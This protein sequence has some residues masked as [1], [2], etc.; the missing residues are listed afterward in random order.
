MDIQV[1]QNYIGEWEAIDASTYDADC[2]QDGFFTTS[3]IGRGKTP[4]DA[5]VDLLDMV[6]DQDY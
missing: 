3:P 1:A 2:D 4:L 5:I 6:E